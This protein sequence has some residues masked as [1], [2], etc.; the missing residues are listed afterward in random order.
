MVGIKHSVQTSKTNNPNKDVSSDAW[1]AEH[2]VDD[3]S[4]PLQKIIVPI[5]TIDGPDWSNPTGSS[6]VVM[7]KN[8]YTGETALCWYDGSSWNR[9]VNQLSVG[10]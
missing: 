1:N 2:S 7:Q 6:Q 10:F 3:S 8:T 5:E 4:I 9:V